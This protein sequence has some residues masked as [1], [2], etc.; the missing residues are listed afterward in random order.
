[1][2]ILKLLFFKS[3][4]KKHT[5]FAIESIKQEFD[6]ILV[7]IEAQ[8]MQNKGSFTWHNRGS[9]ELEFPITLGS[10]EAQ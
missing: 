2:I 1:M 5:N 6:S 9:I 4:Y 3:V 7:S 8:K 10:I